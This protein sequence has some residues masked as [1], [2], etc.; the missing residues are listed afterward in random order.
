V[1]VLQQRIR[2]LLTLKGRP[3]FRLAGI[4]MYERLTEVNACLH[5]M[6]EMQNEP[7]LRQLQQ[8]LDEALVDV[9]GT[10]QDL[11]QAADW[12]AD[13]SQLLSPEDKPERTGE[14]V[15]EQLFGYVETIQAQG[16]DNP[17]LNTFASHIAKTTHNYSPGLFYTYDIEGVPRTNN[18]RESEFREIIRHVLKTTGQKGE[19]RRIILRSGA[20]EAIPHPTTIEQTIE[21]LSDVAPEELQQERERLRNHRKRFK[22]H[23]RSVKQSQK[24]LKELQKQW[25][26]LANR[27]G[28]V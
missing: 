11:R 8:G 27:N 15:Q 25:A 12:L 10:Y 19:T 20:W 16:Q 6:L 23:T 4:E 14:E 1:N 17:V 24:Q 7:R 5:A 26:Q 9:Q 21:A 2:Y 13:I 22:T 3:P 18:D 28:Y